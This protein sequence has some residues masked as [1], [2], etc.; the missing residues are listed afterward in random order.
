MLASFEAYHYQYHTNGNCG[1]VLVVCLPSDAIL[2]LL[3]ST[4]VAAVSILIPGINSNQDCFC[5]ISEL[6]KGGGSVVI[7]RETAAVLSLTTELRITSF[8]REIRLMQR[9]SKAY[10]SLPQP[11]TRPRLQQTSTKGN[12]RKSARL[13]VASYFDTQS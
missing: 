2:V 10:S 11:H 1:L 6:R 5:Y 9:E 3:Y 7:C 13:L 8:I 4:T 12:A